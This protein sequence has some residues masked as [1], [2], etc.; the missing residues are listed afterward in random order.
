MI[1]VVVGGL[2][3]LRSAKIQRH[4][5][6][7]LFVQVL[8]CQLQEL[9]LAQ[10]FAL[11]ILFN[12]SG[13]LRLDPRRERAVSLRIVSGFHLPAG[14]RLALRLCSAF[15]AFYC[16]HFLFVAGGF[17]PALLSL[18]RALYIGPQQP[19]DVLGRVGCALFGLFTQDFLQIVDRRLSDD[20]NLL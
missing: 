19:P 11:Q 8:D 1:S 12:A 9:G 15:Y 18:L 16:S 20:F 4:G 2:P 17:P 3:V 7:F 10:A 5:R 6:L 14:M 13:K